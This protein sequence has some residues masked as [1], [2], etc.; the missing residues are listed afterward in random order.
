MLN[1]IRMGRVNALGLSIF[2]SVE[3]EVDYGDQIQPTELSV[4]IL[5]FN[6]LT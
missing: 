3:R 1:M 6:P 2:K 5:I 4:L